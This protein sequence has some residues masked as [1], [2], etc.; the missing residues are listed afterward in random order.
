M[1]QLQGDG[2]HIS[3]KQLIA[4]QRLGRLTLQKQF[5][6]S[7]L[8]GS[9]LSKR[10]GRGMEFDE[11]RHYQQGDDIRA[12]DWR[13]TARTGKPHTK[14]FR[15]E[16]ERPV[17]ILLDLSPEMYFGSALQLKSAFACQLSALIA[18][19]AQAEGDRVGGLVYNCQQ[20]AEFKPHGGKKGVLRLLNQ[21]CLLHEQG[22][23]QRTLQG[24]SMA[25]QLQRLRQMAHQG[26]LVCLISDLQGLDAAAHKQ[27]MLMRRHHRLCLWQIY[28][29]LEESLPARRC[30]PLPVSDGK[31]QGLLAP[32]S[33]SSR[34]RY[35]QAAQHKQ[36]QLEQQLGPLFHQWQRLSAG[37]PLLA[38]LRIAT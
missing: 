37:E 35:H 18:W 31:H 29:P 33:T 34:Q 10:L 36:Q 14:L 7:M 22:L 8:S 28:D 32:A 25:P 19:S 24:Q 26:A 30:S 9:H 5:G 27:L 11:V 21:I 12:L 16:R 23:T 3:L 17:F 15:E 38:Q 4:L 20:R 2:I 1:K 13:V 6:S